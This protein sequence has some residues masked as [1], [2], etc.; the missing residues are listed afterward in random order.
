MDNKNVLECDHITFAYETDQPVFQEISFA[1]EHGESVGIIGANGTGKSTLLKMMVGLLKYQGNLMVCGMKLEE[2][3]LKE[4]RKRIGFVFQDSNNQLFMPRVYDDIAFG[5]RNYGM[6]REDVEA[7]VNQALERTG[8][9]KLKYRQNYKMSGGEKRMVC[10]AT[11]LA[12]KPE[13]ILLDEPSITLDPFHRRTLIHI[14]NDMPETKIIASHDL[15]FILETCGRVIL[16]SEDGIRADGDS[17]EILKNQALLEDAY[18]ELPFCMQECVFY[19]DQK[20]R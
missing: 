15:D 14:L 4:I 1:I 19:N 9:S 11:V 16:L 3:N 7:A 13:L 5:P 17:E 12:M 8:I 2:R 20:K 10:I 18:L 6:S